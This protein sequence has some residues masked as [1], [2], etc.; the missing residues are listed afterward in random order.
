MTPGTLNY[1]LGDVSNGLAACA[2]DDHVNLA[3]LSL[4][5]FNYGGG[6]PLPPASP[7]ACLDVGPTT[8]HST[9]GRPMTDGLIQFEDL[10][11]VALNY[12]TVSNPIVASRSDDPASAPGDAERLAVV[13][14]HAVAAGETFE[15]RVELHA[16]GRLHAL[17]V[18][19]G[20]DAEIVEPLD[21]RSGGFV[22]VA[23][24][25]TFA[26]GP[27]ALDGAV[28]GRES[29]PLVGDGTFATVRFRAIRDGDPGVGLAQTF[30]R[31]R[32]NRSVAFDQQL[33]T[34]GAAAVSETRL[35]GA[36]PAPFTS[37]TAIRYS[38]AVESNVE[39]AVF[40]IDGRRVRTLEH[41][42]QPVGM[43]RVR[44]DGKDDHGTPLA[45][46]MYYA[47]L[48]VGSRQFT[49]AVMRLAR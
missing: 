25:K 29:A 32:D 18:A 15:A 44:W 12:N 19:L 33:S 30:G 16:G 2:G 37:E 49:R 22:E 38:L 8:D 10:V 23:G 7:V 34:P 35:L 43:H 40:G 14:P 21:A 39:L 17:S 1:Y 11:M 13:A 20:W 6:V 47:R 5:G 36:S 26:A 41:G 24:G 9:N 4:L 45:A 28:L 46:G 48:S 31:D 3:D 42:H 27:A